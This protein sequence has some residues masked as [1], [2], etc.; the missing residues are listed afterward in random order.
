MIRNLLIHPRD[1]MMFR[2]GK[3]FDAGLGARSIGWPMPSTVAGH[4]R[5][6]LWGDRAFPG[7][8]EKLLNDISQVG[9]FFASQ[10]E[11][12][13]WELSLPAP[14]DAAIYGGPRV[15]EIVPLR[16]VDRAEFGG[17]DCDLPDGLLPLR[18]A[19]PKKE[20]DTGPA[21]WTLEQTLLWLTKTD[22]ASWVKAVEKVGHAALPEQARLHVRIG[23]DRRNAV[24]GMLF[25]TVSREFDFDTEFR[26]KERRK[27]DRLVRAC[28]IYSRVEAQGD[29]WTESDGA[30]PMG[31]EQRLAVWGTSESD[32]LPAAPEWLATTPRIRLQLV[33]PGAFRDGWKPGW[34][35]TGD[36]PC[37]P[38]GCPGLK[39][40]LVSAAVKRPLAVSGFDMAKEKEQRRRA[41]RLLASAGSVYFFEVAA[42]DPRSLWLKSICDKEQDQRDGFGIVLVGGW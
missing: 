41:T 20:S 1:P 34:I 39:L 27:G 36:P 29:G 7:A 5:T 12:N 19:L 31:G 11:K 26:R 40:K 38:P 4:I 23:A 6:R 9:P 13:N 33:T 17:A 42:G 22:T 37:E 16:P 35:G 3:P 15:L 25:R 2:D 32:L 14:A 28:A 30:G 10:N 21:F 24:K 8:E 18:G